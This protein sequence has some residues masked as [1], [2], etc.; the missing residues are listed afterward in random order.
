[1]DKYWKDWEG[2]DE[3]FWEHEWGKHGTC[4][5]TLEPRCYPDHKVGDEVVDYF[6]KA[7]SLFKK[8]PSYQWLAEA[9]IYP[10]TTETFTMA[11]IQEALASHHGHDVIINCNSN[12]E[13]NE[14]WYH[15][16][17]YG[18]ISSGVFVAVD[19]VGSPSTCPDTG[20]KYL[21]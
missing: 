20:I 1:M 17:A 7:A 16:N 19:P 12:D 8:L 21:P 5:S 10:S 15:Y 9:G 18:S 11:Q 13:L 4:M 14:R 2:D 6:I 3:S